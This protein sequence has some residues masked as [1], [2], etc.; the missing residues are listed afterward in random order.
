MKKAILGISLIVFSIAGMAQSYPC[1]IAQTGLGVSP[2][3]IAVGSTA[4]FTFSVYNA[5]S[6]PGCTIPAN[7]VT[8]VLSLPSDIA[9]NPKTYQFQSIVSP[10]GGIG[11]YFTWV[12]LPAPDNVV[13]GTNQNPIPNGLGELNV[14]IRVIGI[15]FGANSTAST[16]LNI[17][18]DPPTT[19]NPGNDFS[20]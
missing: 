15:A 19:N 7:S 17:T 14:T 11:A 9:G 3:S 2:S 13:Q 12:Y 6:N 20:S 5:G 16:S 1:D 8:V 4:N 10:A 18:Q